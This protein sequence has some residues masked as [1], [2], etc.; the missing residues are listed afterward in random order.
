[1]K[2]RIPDLPLVALAFAT[3][4]AAGCYG[5]AGQ[6][7][8]D[9][10][11]GHDHAGHEAAPEGV[12][13][14]ADE[15][16]HYTC[17]MHPSVRNQ[18]P[19]SCPM[20]SMALAPVFR[21]ELDSGEIVL[22][23]GRRQQIGVTTARVERRPLAGP[24]RAVG[25]VTYDQSR[26][27]DVTLRVGGW[28]DEL[29]ADRIGQR[30]TEGEPLLTLYS[31]ELFEAQQQYVEALVELG[32]AR[33]LGSPPTMIADLALETRR[34]RLGL[35]DLRPDQLEDLEKRRLPVELVPI[36]APASGHVIEK[37]VVAGAAVEPGMTL[38]RIAGLDRVWVE[39]EVYESELPSLAVGDRATVT[40]RYLPGREL[41]GRITFVYP[42]LDSATRTGR[43][44]VE[45]ANP[46]LALKP[47]M[48]AQVVFERDLGERLAVPQSAVLY[49]GDRDFV[50]LDLGEGRLRP[51][52][53]TVGG[54][55][56][57]WVEILD[58]VGE[59]DLVVTSGNFL[60]AAEARLGLALEHW[61]SRENG[62]GLPAP[63]HDHAGGHG[64]HTAHGNGARP[65]ASAN[66]ARGGHDGHR[67]SA[68]L[69][70][71]TNGGGGG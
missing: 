67:H 56:G 5:A 38:L 57:E 60:V 11:A 21:R 55:A 37:N 40:L 30:V 9:P 39:A 20:C 58:G 34:Q 28:I 12:V 2:A 6:T 45:L 31:P 14:A 26:L 43:V 18:G 27:T 59:G 41:H 61:G 8:S 19:G 48:Y 54:Q 51:Q 1:M 36:M 63:A 7:S 29:H 17:S 69:P 52:A 23:A 22:D 32:E 50:F 65:P 46:D 16:A 47:G 24:V 35:A 42:W 70:A 13:A 3:A 10:A 68:A 62:R 49:A 66:G 33:M 25:M 15:I 44:R 64:A 53:V 4:L 71:P